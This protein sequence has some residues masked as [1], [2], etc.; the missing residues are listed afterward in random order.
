VLYV[1]HYTPVDLIPKLYSLK[2]YFWLCVLHQGHS[3]WSGSVGGV[4][5]LLWV[6]EFNGQ[7]SEWK[8]IYFE[9]KKLI[10]LNQEI[11]KYW[12]ILKEIW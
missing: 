5:W 11:Q 4:V 1:F 12:A 9:L 10:F 8:S 7:Q 6:A 3:W 2:H